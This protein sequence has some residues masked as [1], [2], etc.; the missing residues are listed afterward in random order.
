VP[1]APAFY[2]HPQTVDD[3]VDQTVG[4]ALDLFGLD[5]GAV[6]R[7]EGSRQAAGGPAA[8]PAEA[9]AAPAEPETIS[10]EEET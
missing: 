3:I 9:G 2:H 5:V 4:R 7:W 6:R 10:W 1:P 8:W